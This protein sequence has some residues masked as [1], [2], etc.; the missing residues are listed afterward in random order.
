MKWRIFWLLAGPLAAWLVF[1]ACLPMGATQAKTLGLGAWMVLWWI[2][3]PV[4]LAVTALLP[5]VFF[6][7]LNLMPVRQ[8]AAYY[9]HDIVFLFLGGFL[10][11]LAM[12][13]HRLHERIALLI[14]LKTG[15][16][17]IKVLLGFMLATGF[18][19]MWISN[20]ATTLMMLPMATSVLPV[21]NNATFGRR[22]LLAIAYSSSLGGMATLI[23]TPPNVVLRGQLQAAGL[24]ELSF[25]AW[26]GLALPI[27]L[28][29]GALLY[30]LLGYGLKHMQ[31]SAIDQIRQRKHALGKPGPEEKRVA[32][33]FAATAAAWIFRPLLEQLSGLPL[34]D[35][36]IAM[37][38]GLLMFMVP[39]TKAGKALLDW[40]DTRKMAWGI[41]LL[42]GGG[43]SLAAALEQAGIIQSLGMAAA[44]WGSGGLFALILG[45][46]ALALFL[47]EIMSNVALVSIL[48][49]VVLE[50][51]KS[52]DIN[53]LQLAIPVTLAA[54]C[55]FMLPMA[56]PPNALV[57]AGG[58]L[59]V[60]HMS[61]YGIWMNLASV[62]VI[63]LAA[64][65][66]LP[67]W[68]N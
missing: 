1:L 25:F 40:D 8:T 39:S 32:L 41:I 64:W 4:N 47:T 2:S 24:G 31:G 19:S 49:P 10:I 50:L 20:T 33:I 35:T 57:F 48:L 30:M 28:V 54:S 43:L 45:L 58:Q 36:G 6:P 65:Q 51:A 56:T 29:L 37:A 38:G 13:K 26:L 3:Q 46:T 12:E 67:L 53:P 42:F 63:S 44:D 9:G 62:L 21:F 52:L 60:S 5:L 27:T 15:G 23:G 68:L 16:R 17:P 18:L 14:L 59:K 61:R 66:F 55:A 22:L 34:N 7:L 11:G